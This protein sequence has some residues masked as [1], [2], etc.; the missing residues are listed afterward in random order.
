MKDNQTNKQT[1]E[2]KKKK[3]LL[4]ES[5]SNRKINETKCTTHR[6]NKRAE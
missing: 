3:L 4:F 6:A 5:V 1:R 2:K